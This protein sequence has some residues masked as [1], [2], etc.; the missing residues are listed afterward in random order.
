MKKRNNLITHEALQ[1]AI[2]RY[3][4]DG[5]RIVKLPQQKSISSALVGRR[6]SHTEVELDPHR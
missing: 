6:W 2:S 3:L 4:K 1:Q 5:G